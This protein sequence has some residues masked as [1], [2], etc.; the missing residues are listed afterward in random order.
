[1]ASATLDTRGA[2]SA[3][4][5][6]NTAQT[7][8]PLWQRTIGRITIAAAFV[9]AA[10]LAASYAL[11]VPYNFYA[12]AGVGLLVLG[13]LVKWFFSAASTKKADQAA[14][15]DPAQ[16]LGA[17]RPSQAGRNA[18][19]DLVLPA[20][21]PEAASLTAEAPAEAPAPA[22]APAAAARG[23]LFGLGRRRSAEKASPAAAA[24][25]PAGTP[26]RRGSGEG[27]DALPRTA[28][29][30]SVKSVAD[31]ASAVNTSGEGQ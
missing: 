19:R 16:T 1:M 14:G 4:S 5:T 6:A 17:R 11:P 22:P 20:A 27:A 30:G 28:S 9:F 18:T 15:S 31:S 26:A 13:A 23:G 25:S 3:V 24:A 29:A 10:N 8:R 21:T 2:A 7:Q 12:T